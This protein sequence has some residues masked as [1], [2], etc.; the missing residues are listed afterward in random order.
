MRLE[1]AQNLICRFYA[2]ELRLL[3]LRKNKNYPDS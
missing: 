1:A 3:V 2:I